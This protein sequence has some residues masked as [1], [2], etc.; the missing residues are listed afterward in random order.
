M[1]RKSGLSV[2]AYHHDATDTGEALTSRLM[3]SAKLAGH[4]PSKSNCL[5]PGSVVTVIG[6]HEK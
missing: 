5:T 2:E 6:R 1:D 3:G 4:A